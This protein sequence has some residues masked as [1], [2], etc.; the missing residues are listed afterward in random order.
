ML[1]VE[2]EI[3]TGLEPEAAMT[4]SCWLDGKTHLPGEGLETRVCGDLL[5]LYSCGSGKGSA[6][7]TGEKESNSRALCGKLSR[8]TFKENTIKKPGLI[9]IIFQ[10]WQSPGSGGLETMRW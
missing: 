8:L 5:L 6:R 2:P 9:V 3:T 10:E 1:G 7:E 4:P